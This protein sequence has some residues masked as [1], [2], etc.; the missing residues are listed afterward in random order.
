MTAVLLSA[1]TLLPFFWMLSTSFKNYG[2]IM[3]LPIQ[4]IPKNPTLKNFSDLFRKEGMTVSMLNSLVVS[5][6][7]VALSLIHI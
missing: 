1:V 5:V 2:A 6:S 7:S 3:A 4:W